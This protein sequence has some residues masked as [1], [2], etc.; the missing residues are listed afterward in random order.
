[1]YT[2]LECSQYTSEKVLLANHANVR[3]LCCMR[4]PQL[5]FLLVRR[6]LLSDQHQSCLLLGFALNEQSLTTDHKESQN[7]LQPK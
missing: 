5:I 4:T 3:L 7:R 1:M 2:W 6:D